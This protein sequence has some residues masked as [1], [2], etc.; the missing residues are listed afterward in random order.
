MPGL[1]VRLAVAFLLV[2]Q[3]IRWLCS[4]WLV[5]GTTGVNASAG[6]SNLELRPKPPRL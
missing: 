2:A 4:L 6:L 3:E 1:I 5:E